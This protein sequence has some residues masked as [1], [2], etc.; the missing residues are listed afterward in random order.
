MEPKLWWKMPSFLTC[1]SEEKEDL[2]LPTEFDEPLP[3]R[4][5]I[6]FDDFDEVSQED[7][8]FMKIVFSKADD[9]EVLVFVLTADSTAANK[10]CKLNHWRRIGP[11]EGSYDLAAKHRLSDGKFDDPAWIPMTW[12]KRQLERLLQCHGFTDTEIH[13]L[14]VQNEENPYDLLKRA[15]RRRNQVAVAQL[16]IP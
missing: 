9:Y 5:I 8:N 11:M 2:T 16:L 4:P 13:A 12:G 7:L 10:L 3:K 6:V 14:D 1:G 15:K